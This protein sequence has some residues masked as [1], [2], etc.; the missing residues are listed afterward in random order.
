MYL[1]SRHLINLSLLKL[2]QIRA[3]LDESL[4]PISTLTVGDVKNV[5]SKDNIRTTTSANAG[6]SINILD[7]KISQKDDILVANR[8]LTCFELFHKCYQIDMLT[9]GERDFGQHRNPRQSMLADNILTTERI[10]QGGTR[11]SSINAIETIGVGECRRA[12]TLAPTGFSL[13][14]LRLDNSTYNSFHPKDGKVPQIEVEDYNLEQWF[15]L[16]KAELGQ[17]GPDSEQLPQLSILQQLAE[18]LCNS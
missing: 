3:N 10:P 11:D 17:S 16:P 12:T 15:L 1:G 4:T 9:V 8:F 13:S 2:L 18:T 7:S 14:A 6:F 5:F